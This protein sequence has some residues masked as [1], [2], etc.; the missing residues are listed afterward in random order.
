MM[1]LNS[2]FAFIIGTPILIII[3]IIRYIKAKL[4]K[5][6]FVDYKEISIVLFSMYIMALI[7]ITLLPIYT[8]G[9]VEASANVVPVINTVKDIEGVTSAPSNLKGYMITFWIINIFGNLFLLVPLA[10]ITPIIFKR[11]RSL[12][13]A[14]LL[15]VSVSVL[16]EFLQ[17]LSM[18]VGNIRSVDIDDVILNS[19]GSIIGFSIFKAIN[20]KFKLIV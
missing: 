13:S 2:Q 1:L 17:Y 6:N 5:R 16:I 18:F 8:F 4:L 12:K 11:F 10:A 14:M 3:E 7:S 20:R 15:C 9:K 19:L